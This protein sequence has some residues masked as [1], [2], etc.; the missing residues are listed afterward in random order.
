MAGRV[1]DSA[2]RFKKTGN[3]GGGKPGSAKRV[4][5]KK[6]QEAWPLITDMLVKTAKD[7][8]FSITRWLWDESGLGQDVPKKQKRVSFAKT[9]MDELKRQ[10]AEK[11][12]AANAQT[13]NAQAAS[14]KQA[15]E[16]AK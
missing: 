16:T 3:G 2:G 13:E 11:A 8:D 1:R 10:E 4:M 14:E 6:V 12:Q 5:Q 9:L 7:G 15:T